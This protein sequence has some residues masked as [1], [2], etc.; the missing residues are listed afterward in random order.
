MIKNNLRI[1]MAM[2]DTK[3]SK[4]AERT[5]IAKSTISNF[6]NGKTDIK[7]STLISL[8]IFFKC[9]LSDLIELSFED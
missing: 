7:L 2:N 3:A 1:V 8:C 6:I 4:V 5:G 9:Q